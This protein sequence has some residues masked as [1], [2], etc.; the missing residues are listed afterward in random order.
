MIEDVFLTYANEPTKDNL[1]YFDSVYEIVV[2]ELQIDLQ[3]VPEI[4]RIIPQLVNINEPQKF[5]ERVNQKGN[6]NRYDDHFDDM[7][8]HAVEAITSQRVGHYIDLYYARERGNK[9]TRTIELLKRAC[10]NCDHRETVHK[11]LGEDLCEEG[12]QRKCY[13]CYQLVFRGILNQIVNGIEYEDIVD[14]EKALFWSS[15][16]SSMRTDPVIVEKNSPSFRCGLEGRGSFSLSF[17]SFADGMLGNSY[18]AFNDF[19]FALASYSLTTFLISNNR[20]KLK[21]C[22]YC[23]KY[24]IARDIKRKRCCYSRECVRKAEREK[25]RIQRD[26]DPVRYL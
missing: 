21:C 3:N 20:E 26:S 15:E 5:L 2:Q 16:I 18:T 1:K 22:S 6:I 12:F 24:F 19:F 14:I 8:R 25:K 13:E 10:F 7:L 23:G 11:Y 17:Q 4:I 9:N